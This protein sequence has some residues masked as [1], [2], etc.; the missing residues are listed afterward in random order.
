[1]GPSLR[2]WVT[3]TTFWWDPTSIIPVQDL[4]HLV[5][6]CDG[7]MPLTVT[8]VKDP[9]T[10]VPTPFRMPGTQ[11]SLQVTLY[12]TQ[13]TSSAEL[14]QL[15][16]SLPSSY[17]LLHLVGPLPDRVPVTIRS[18][19]VVFWNTTNPVALRTWIRT[20]SS[21]V[22]HVAIRFDPLQSLPQLPDDFAWV[23]QARRSFYVYTPMPAV[24]KTPSA[25]HLLARFHYP[26]D[27]SVLALGSV[28]LTH[29]FMLSVSYRDT[30]FPP[31]V[32]CVMF[33]VQPY[34]IDQ[35][36]RRVWIQHWTNVIRRLSVI[37][38][39]RLDVYLQVPESCLDWIA[40]VA[41]L[42]L[43]D[44]FH[45]SKKRKGRLILSPFQPASD[46]NEWGQDIQTA[47]PK[48]SASAC[49]LVVV[50]VPLE[51]DLHALVPFLSSFDS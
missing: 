39:H 41:S 46:S 6:H 47:C 3:T 24:P 31:L 44:V 15:V 22:D 42:V 27:L 32:R 21:R 1:M 17:R 49:E 14:E 19:A 16:A 48:L 2:T 33:H 20:Y 36:S 23:C 30:A 38:S 4:D 40:T 26:A 37:E 35:E 11:A 28:S 9:E 5:I 34:E 50:P 18:S 29:Q 13:Y 25:I 51:H 12:T 7:G 43:T 45:P 8:E 10:M